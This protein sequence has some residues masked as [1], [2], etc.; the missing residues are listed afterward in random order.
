M[1]KTSA[2]LST[3]NREKFALLQYC[4]KL[5]IKIKNLL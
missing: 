5:F 2:K 1:Q 3:K 4:I